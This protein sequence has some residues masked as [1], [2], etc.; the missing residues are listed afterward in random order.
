MLKQL[1]EYEKLPMGVI[2]TGLISNSPTGYFANTEGSSILRF[3]V[4][5]RIEGWVVY[6]G[7]ISRDIEWIKNHGDKSSTEEY[8]RNAFPC[9]DEL[10]KLYAR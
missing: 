9:S 10:F 2:S 7:E 5:K 1:E 3:V 6:F 4:I 8:I